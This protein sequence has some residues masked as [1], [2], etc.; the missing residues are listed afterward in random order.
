M[1]TRFG[2]GSAALVTAVLCA[3]HDPAQPPPPPPSPALYS[4]LTLDRPVGFIDQTPSW[5]GLSLL[6]EGAHSLHIVSMD[7]FENRLRYAGCANVCDDSTHWWTATVD[8]NPRGFYSNSGAAITPGGLHVVYMSDGPTVRHAFCPGACQ[9]A[10][11]WQ[12]GDLFYGD[13]G[14]NGPETT[15][16]AADS[17]GRLHLIYTTR[18][19]FR[20]A[21]CSGLCGDSAAW[22]S[23]RLDTIL[24]F[25]FS[26]I[27]SAQGVPHVVYRGP[28]LR[29][30][31]CAAACTDS[32]G[33]TSIKVDSSPAAGMALSLAPD[34]R[35]HV[36]YFVGD[37]VHYATCGGGCTSPAAWQSVVL[38]KQSSSV[39][40][41]SQN[42]SVYLATNLDHVDVAR[43]A[44]N[45]LT[46][47]NWESV[48]VDSARGGG[49]LALAVD[50][51]GRAEVASTS[52]RLQLTHFTQ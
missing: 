3:C 49:Y 8:S 35:L 17:A 19:G 46:A 45:C 43:C 31:T 6:P 1:T 36:A 23:T 29:Y 5:A 40:I 12:V 48:S 42:G 30:A 32:A 20:Y 25:G 52:T 21:E 9:I 28:G 13:I 38:G 2:V 51:A 27:S 10:A 47:G 24:P 15:P 18:S 39:A 14:G 22:S 7:W 37:T 44:A 11:N 50:S 41:L 34:G 16:L 26:I 4:I 33:W